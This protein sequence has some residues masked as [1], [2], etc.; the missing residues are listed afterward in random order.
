MTR[1]LTVFFMAISYLSALGSREVRDSPFRH[2][3]AALSSEGNARART[4]KNSRC[5]RAWVEVEV[6]AFRL[7]CFPAPLV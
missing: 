6:V 7:A 2:D 4:V 5:G 3:E 1:F